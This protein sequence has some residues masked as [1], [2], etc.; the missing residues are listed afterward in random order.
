MQTVS[1]LPRQLSV[2]AS[3]ITSVWVGLAWACFGAP[4]APAQEPSHTWAP[5][6]DTANVSDFIV[7]HHDPKTQRVLLEVGE[8]A[9][10]VLRVSTLASQA[11]W[12]LDRGTIRFDVAPSVLSFRNQGETLEVH[13][14][15]PISG[16][17][18]VDTLAIVGS[19]SGMWL[20]DAT[21]LLFG[22]AF[23]VAD[24]MAWVGEN[25]VFDSAR[26][27]VL[28]SSIEQGPSFAH[29]DV[30]TT[31]DVH[32]GSAWLEE[33]SADPEILTVVQRHIF[34]TTEPGFLPVPT[35]GRVGINGVPLADVEQSDAPRNRVPRWRDL[36]ALDV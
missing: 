9:R 10:P 36:T 22:D 4:A 2:L 7:F 11:D 24:V 13:T 27:S 30:R 17:A 28:G 5:S 32:G 26:S 25:A 21:P 20:A 1:D 12:P 31:F 18:F 29:V 35:D 23:G 8:D 34:F 15:D 16:N 3:T 19:R 33:R 6:S 14:L